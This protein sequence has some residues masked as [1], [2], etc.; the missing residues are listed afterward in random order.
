MR[1][2]PKIVILLAFVAV[3]GCTE[4]EDIVMVVPQGSQ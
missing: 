1:K 2:L 3:S 4:R